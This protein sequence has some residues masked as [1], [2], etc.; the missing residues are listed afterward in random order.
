MFRTKFADKI[1]TKILG[2]IFFFFENR[3]F[4]EKMWKHFVERGRSQM[5]IWCMHF[6]CWM[7]KAT[8]THTQNM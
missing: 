6:A 4:Y 2:S 7:R 1:K 3:A 5:T 8:N